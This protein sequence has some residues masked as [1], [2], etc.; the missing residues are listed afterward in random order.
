MFFVRTSNR[1]DFLVTDFEL[2]ETNP[3]TQFI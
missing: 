2:N 3:L 1:L